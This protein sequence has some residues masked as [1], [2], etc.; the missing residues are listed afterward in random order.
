MIEI[1]IDNWTDF[2][3]IIADRNINAQFYSF[4]DVYFIYG[5]DGF[6][7][8]TISLDKDDGSDVIDFETNYQNLWNKQLDYRDEAGVL[9]THISPRKMGQFTYFTGS[10]DGTQVGDGAQ[11]LFKMLASDPSKS[12]D[13]SFNEDVSIKSGEIFYTDAP[14]GAYLNVEVV[15][16][17]DGVIGRQLNKVPLLGSGRIDVLSEDSNTIPQGL[18]IKIS[19][20]NADG[21]GESD[22]ASDFKVC[23][24]IELYR[25]NII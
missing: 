10:G 17:V 3:Q 1:Q 21:M 25:T 13:I 22:P 19:V 20:H 7:L 9:K 23:G 18:S 16:P 12:K 8:F 15:H 2:K 4:G 11:I 6:L 14:L 5:K 24:F